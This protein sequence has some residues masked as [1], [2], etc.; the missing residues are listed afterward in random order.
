MTYYIIELGSGKLVGRDGFLYER[1]QWSRHPELLMRFDSLEWASA[2][3]SGQRGWSLRGFEPI[4]GEDI[5]E[6]SSARAKASRNERRAISHERN[7]IPAGVNGVN[8][9]MHIMRSQCASIVG[10]A[11]AAS[12]RRVALDYCVQND[13]DPKTH[14]SKELLHE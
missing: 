3:I 6:L 2:Y 14:L 10:Y 7:G 13:L 12:K 9:A 1:A 11:S 8:V 5:P 4:C